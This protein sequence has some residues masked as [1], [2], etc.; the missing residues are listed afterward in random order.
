[1]GIARNEILCDGCGREASP[2]H[3]R[4]RIKRLEWATRFRPIRINVLLLTAAAP[5][6]EDDFYD[7][8]ESG[9]SVHPGDGLF[10]ALGISARG[11]QVG[12]SDREALLGEFQRRGFFL[13]A[14]SECPLEAAEIPPAMD[15]LAATI[16]RRIRYSYKPRAVVFLSADLKSLETTL[17]QALPGTHVL[18]AGDGFTSTSRGSWTAVERFQAAISAA[19][20]T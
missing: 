16:V 15:R 20:Q 8:S 14:V 17:K 19:L 13:S 1:M 18:D 6:I 11:N 3:I 10:A 12:V 4:D 9:G 2:E 5:Q 7:I